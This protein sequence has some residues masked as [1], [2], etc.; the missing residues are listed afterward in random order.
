MV[1][2]FI[3]AILFSSTDLQAFVLLSGPTEARMDVTEENPRIVFELSLNPPSIK[4]KDEFLDGA[5]A[6]LSDEDFWLTL[7]QLAIRPWNDVAD[8]YL[9]MDVAFSDYATLDKEDRIFSIVVG[10][11]NL[12]T[13]AYAAPGIEGKT[14]VD[15]DIAVSERGATARSLAFTLMHEIGHCLGLGHNHSDYSA[16]MGYARTDRSLNLGLDDEAG[17]IYLYPLSTIGEPQELAGCGV[18]SGSTPNSTTLALVL[19]TPICLPLTRRLREKFKPR[20]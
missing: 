1:L 9:E 7:V 13:S 2:I 19:L 5:Y 20:A 12:T 11:T 8:S 10:K 18:I 16:V 4:E 3:L 14:I 6:D 17:L 15:C